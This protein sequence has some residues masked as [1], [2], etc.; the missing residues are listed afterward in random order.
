[1]S[2][3]RDGKPYNGLRKC[4]RLSIERFNPERGSIERFVVT[5]PRHANAERRDYADVFSTNV[6]PHRGNLT[7]KRERAES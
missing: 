7:R 6:L 4:D 3:Q 5:F 1:M 2:R